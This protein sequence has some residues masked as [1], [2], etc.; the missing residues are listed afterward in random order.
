MTK[1]K[2]YYLMIGAVIGL[3]VTLSSAMFFNRQRSASYD[4]ILAKSAIIADTVIIGTTDS[5]DGYLMLMSKEGKSK[6]VLGFD[7]K[8]NSLISMF[9]AN[10]DCI[11]LNSR[12]LPNVRII[13]PK[14]I[15]SKR[16]K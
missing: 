15:S 13:K 2:V 3:F 10:G 14:I 6:L 7:K 1:L 12:D 16:K 8:G 5:G 11:N 4:S 9:D